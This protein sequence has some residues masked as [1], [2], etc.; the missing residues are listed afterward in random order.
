MKIEGE[1]DYSGYDPTKDI[2]PDQLMISVDEDGWFLCQFSD[3]TKDNKP[4]YQ[5]RGHNNPHEALDQWADDTNFY[6]GN[7]NNNE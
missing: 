4:I 3:K 1:P 7:D 2:F 6:L 5:S